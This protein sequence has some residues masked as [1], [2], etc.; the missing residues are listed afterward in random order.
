ME[1]RG[2]KKKEGGA[3]VTMHVGVTPAQYEALRDRAHRLGVSMSSLI[4]KFI[5][6][7]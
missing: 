3:N 4:R 1:T 5:D 2:R 6:E 7:N